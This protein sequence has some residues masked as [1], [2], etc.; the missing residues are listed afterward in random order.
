M[1]NG[2]PVRRVGV[3]EVANNAPEIMGH[4]IKHTVKLFPAGMRWR[5]Q[6]NGAFNSLKACI[7][8][9]LGASPAMIQP[10][11]QGGRANR[12][13][14]QRVIRNELSLRATIVTLRDLIQ[15]GRRDT[16]EVGQ[17]TFCREWCQDV[18]IGRA[19]CRERV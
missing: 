9:R 16:I 14:D 7:V 10:V 17:G 8:G 18:K 6:M 5:G 1:V 4:A 2:M 13:V 11:G 3:N 19:S 12:D 15:A